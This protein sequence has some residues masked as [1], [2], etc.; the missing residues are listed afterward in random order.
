MTTVELHIIICKFMCNTVSLCFSVLNSRYLHVPCAASEAS[1][2]RR[3]SAPVVYSSALPGY[4]LTERR[5]SEPS[6]LVAQGAHGSR[7]RGSEPLVTGF[8]SQQ[9]VSQHP[10]GD[11]AEEEEDAVAE[12]APQGKRRTAVSLHFPFTPVP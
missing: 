1:G 8:F 5:G 12:A 6:L 3:G 4:T 10:P 9:Q 7:R 2:T 11:I